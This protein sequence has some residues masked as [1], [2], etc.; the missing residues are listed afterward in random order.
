M[1]PNFVTTTEAVDF[2]FYVIFGISAVM[3][4][5]ITVTLLWFVWR[6]NRK[7]QPIPLSQ[8]DSNITLEI[9]WTV[10]PTILVMIMF[11]YGWEGYLSLRRIPDN[12]MPVDAHARMWSWLFTYEN[13]KTSDKLYVPVGQP[14]KVKLTSEDVLHSFFVPAFRVKRDTVP[15][16]TNYVW[17][18]ADEKG[19]YNLFCAEYCGVGHADMVT[20]VEALPE[21]EF[22]DWLQST[23]DTA[24]ALPGKALLE[25]YGCLGCHSLDGSRKVGPSFLG[26]AGRETIVTVNGSEQTV[27]VDRDYLARAI[28]EPNAEIVKGYPPAMP[29]FADS[30]SPEEL[31][32]MIDY[33]MQGEPEEGSGKAEQMGEVESE[34]ARDS[35]Q[36]VEPETK[37]AG[38]AEPEEKR[39]QKETEPPGPTALDGMKL[40]QDNGCLGCHSTDGS[41]MV[42]PSFKGVFGRQVEVEKGGE[43][44]TLNSDRDYLRRAIQEPAVEI[45]KGYPPVMPASGLSDAE[46]EAIIDSL[47]EMK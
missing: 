26:I 34:Q 41:R 10:I 40:L 27:T 47:E 23:E 22:D 7:R 19:S 35:G 14:V 15:G 31:Q 36:P 16:M 32:Q 44:L 42:G 5:G 37:S 24:G 25:K 18:V 6:Y 13:G 9:V 30:V 12:A 4:I 2:A 39:E 3:L 20:T 28:N 29:S 43:S 1:K 38:E 11:W 33:L 17:F 45:V 46:V 21:A 8:K